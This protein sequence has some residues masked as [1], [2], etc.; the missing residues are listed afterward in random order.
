MFIA[1]LPAGYLLAR[2]LAR[3]RPNRKRLVLTGL[4]ASLLPDLDLFWFYL[5]DGRQTAHHA[6]LFHTPLFWISLAAIASVIAWLTAWKAAQPFIR[7]ALL[8]VLLHMV[9]D[10]VAAEI[11]WLKP[12]APYEVNLVHVPAGHDWWVWNFVLH[13]T[14]LLEMGIVAAAALAFWNDRNAPSVEDG[15]AR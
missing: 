10:S 4:G 15:T 9:L 8:S 3:K 12:F 13:W 11:A 5:V 14:F 7:V 6:Y 2:H 1:H